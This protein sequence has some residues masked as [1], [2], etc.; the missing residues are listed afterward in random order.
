M[1]WRSLKPSAVSLWCLVVFLVDAYAEPFDFYCSG[2]RSRMVGCAGIAISE[3]YESAYQNPALISAK[4]NL[5]AGYVF[6]S[7]DM[8]VY[9]QDQKVTRVS[10]ILENVSLLHVGLAVPLS[11]FSFIFERSRILENVSVGVVAALPTSGKIAEVG[12][13]DT[14]IPFPIMYGNRNTRFSTYVGLSGRVPFERFKIYA[15]LGLNTLATIPIDIIT[16]FSPD[17]DIIG[18]KGY[19][20]L[21]ESVVAGLAF[22]FERESFFLRAGAT[23][24]TKNQIDI[25]TTISVNLVGDEKVLHIMAMVIDSYTPTCVG[26]GIGGGIKLSSLKLSVGADLVHYRFSEMKLPLLEIKEVSPE[27]LKGLL[28]SANL[29]ELQDVLVMKGGL[30][31]DI[32]DVIGEADIIAGAGISMFPSPIKSQNGTLFVDSDRMSVLGGL[33]ARF[34]SPA[35]VKGDVELIL[36]G[37]VHLLKERLFEETKTRI[38]G[39][40]PVISGTLNLLF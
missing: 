30:S 2:S 21:N 17:R 23:A 7:Q 20:S 9:L 10:K 22:E 16:S 4:R 27:Q 32:Y 15:G 24:R 1:T 35:V 14:K 12:T 11:D 3:G 40:L 31:A 13:I 37:G 39:S 6:S 38:G 18:F 28:P 29:P 19:F 36:S 33:G 5:G 25:P 26:G 8:D 34:K